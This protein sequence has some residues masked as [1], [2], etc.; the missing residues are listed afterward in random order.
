MCPAETE[1]EQ[2][3][4]D[5]DIDVFPPVAYSIIRPKESWRSV[6]RIAWSTCGACEQNI[7]DCRCPQLVEPRGIQRIRELERERPPYGS[8]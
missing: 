6:L 4:I 7:L 1:D 3:E 8:T 2:P 5:V